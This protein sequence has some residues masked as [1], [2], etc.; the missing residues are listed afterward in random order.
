MCRPITV[1]HLPAACSHWRALLAVVWDTCAR[2]VLWPV[3]R[4]SAWQ[5]VCTL[6]SQATDCLCTHLWQCARTRRSAWMRRLPVRTRARGP[7]RRCAESVQDALH[8]PQTRAL[9]VLCS[10]PVELT[11]FSLSAPLRAIPACARLQVAASSRCEARPMVFALL[12][13]ADQAEDSSKARYQ[14]LVR[15]YSREELQY[16]D[17]HCQKYVTAWDANNHIYEQPS[18][19]ENL[20]SPSTAVMRQPQA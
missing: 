16:C 14:S 8:L 13:A 11:L 1:Q 15:L 6:L 4:R 18:I 2:R 7:T 12:R 10:Q 3:H 17:H 5:G 20:S 19:Y 9:C